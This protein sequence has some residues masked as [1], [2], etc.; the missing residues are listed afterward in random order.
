MAVTYAGCEY[1]GALTNW[2]DDHGEPACAPGTGCSTPLRKKRV[3]QPQ[4]LK[5]RTSKPRK[6]APVQQWSAR[7]RKRFQ[8]LFGGERQDV[9][10]QLQ[11]AARPRA[12][13]RADW[14]KRDSVEVTLLDETRSLAEWAATLQVTTSVLKSRA[15]RYQRSLAEEIATRLIEERNRKASTAAVARTLGITADAL[16]KRARKYGIEAALTMER[17]QCSGGRPA[18]RGV[19]IER[20]AVHFNL[21]RQALYKAAK[22]A[23]RTLDEEIEFRLA[24]QRRDRRAA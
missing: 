13:R 14:P 11:C 21:T 5:Q 10:Q 15:Y 18:P 19:S 1:C 12:R 20:I 4:R 3:E 6:S 2:R 22:L 24:K 7:M 8:A 16:R 17:R 9:A 23:G